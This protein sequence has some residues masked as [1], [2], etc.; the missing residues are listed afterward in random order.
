MKN[1]PHVKKHLLASAIAGL[2]ALPVMAQTPPAAPAAPAAEDAPVSIVVTGTRAVNR[3]ALDTA[4]PIDIVSSEALKNVGVTEINQALSVALPSLNFPRPGL[5][6]GTDT[7]RPAT[8]RGL[9]PDQTLVLVN[10]KRLHSSALVNLNGTIGRGSSSADLNTIPVG[11]VKSIEVLRDGA[12]AQ[13]GSDAIAGVVNLRLRTDKKGGEITTSY[14][15]RKTEYEFFTGAL[16]AGANFSAVNSRKVTDGETATISG[17]KGMQLGDAGY[18]V[19]SG[20]YKDQKH[21][22]RSGY[23]VRQQYPLVGTAFD[24]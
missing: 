20:E 8:L 18:L 24:P 4:A 9:A 13:Y 10:S 16:P 17:W 14:G 22:E 11:M 15:A 21:T 3:T 12:S 7:I 6:D 19:L 2:F 23:D 1:A 5:A